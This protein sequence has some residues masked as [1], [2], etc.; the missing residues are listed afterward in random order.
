MFYAVIQINSN[1]LIQ[2]E[3]QMKK[4]DFFQTVK[5]LSKNTIGREIVWDFIR[6]NYNDLLD[7]YGLD[8]PRLGQMLIDITFSFETEYLFNEVNIF[9]S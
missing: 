8:D 6:I 2:E 4:A 1:R 7:K 3:S 9:F 5:F